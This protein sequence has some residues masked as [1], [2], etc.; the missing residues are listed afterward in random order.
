MNR[1]FR[2]QGL[3]NLLHLQEEQAAGRLAAAHAQLHQA[4]QDVADSRR[5]LGTATLEQVSSAQAMALAAAQRQGA[6][7]QI[8]EKEAQKTYAQEIVGRRQGEWSVKRRQAATLEKLETKHVAAMTAEDLAKEQLVLDE[9]AT[10]RAAH[11][12][13]DKQNVKNA[14]DTQQSPALTEQIGSLKNA[15]KFLGGRA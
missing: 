14:A 9:L 5:S 1:A 8:A 15:Q 13:E 11:Q 3:L 4:E 12:S 2:L 7:M 6:R 10:V